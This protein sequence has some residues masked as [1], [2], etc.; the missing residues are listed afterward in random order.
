MKIGGNAMGEGSKTVYIHVGTPKTGTSAI[1]SFCAS[2]RQTLQK[3]RVCYPDLGYRFEGIGINRNANFLVHKCFRSDKKRDHE[4]EEDLTREGMEKIRGLLEHCDTLVLSDEQFW[5]NRDFDAGR[6]ERF[7]LWFE[8]MGAT[9]KVIVYLRRQ[10]QLIQSYWAQQVKETMTMDF[11]E[12]LSS[13]KYR[14]FRLD[15]LAR[16]EEIERGIGRN[17]LIVR[18]YEKEQYLGEQPTIISDFMHI[19]GLGLDGF[20]LPEKSVNVSLVGKYLEV[21]RILNSL[22]EFKTK[23]NYIVP[24]LTACQLKEQKEIGLPEPV[25][26]T[27]EQR[28]AFM[29]Q[30][31]ESN[32]LIAGRYLQKE[33]DRLFVH[34][35]EY[36]GQEEAS[37]YDSAELVR[38]CGEV[39]SR[40]HREQ[41]HQ[42]SAV[43][44][45]LKKLKNKWKL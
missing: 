4:Q 29:E 12:Y 17:N 20:I 27:G 38:V 37:G 43:K 31:E 44:T 7:R 32:S 24:Y 6:W 18:V 14:Y 23:K 26:F 33:D 16:L 8:Q 40:M 9:L 19:L 11:S 3:H 41:S 45:F 15:Y 25:Y 35:P 5:N 36:T 39:I 2:N 42:D 13:G 10:D 28:R 21:K 1:Q 30:Y 34:E 22:P